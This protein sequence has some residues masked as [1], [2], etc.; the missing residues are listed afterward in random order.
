MEI[1]EVLEVEVI[2]GEGYFLYKES[3]FVVGY[4]IE[5]LWVVVIRC[6]EVI[7]E[8]LSLIKGVFKVIKVLVLVGW[9]LN[10]LIKLVVGRVYN[11]RVVRFFFLFD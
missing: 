3:V 4:I 1:Y 8:F 9:V 10:V 2:L 5:M 7:V 6:G 11:Y